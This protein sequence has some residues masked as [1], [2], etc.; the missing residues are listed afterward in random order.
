MWKSKLSR[1]LLLVAVITLLA[2]IP[3]AQVQ[4]EEPTGATIWTDKPDYSPEE[5]VTIFGTGFNALTGVTVTIE[6]PDR[7]MDT[8]SATTDDSGSFSCTYLLDGI[9]GTYLVTATDGTKMATTTF[10]DAISID[11]VSPSDSG[12]NPKTSFLTTDNV[13]ATI[14]Y[15][16]TGPNTVDAYLVTSIPS[17]SNPS[18]SDIRGSPTTVT[19]SE[20]TLTQLIWNAPTTA[21]TTYYIILDLNQ[22]GN[23]Q[24]SN[25]PISSIFTVSVPQCEVTFD[26]TGLDGDATSTVVSYEIDGGA[27]TDLAYGDLPETVWVDAGSEPPAPLYPMKSMVAH[28]RTLL[29]V[30]FRRRFGLTRGLR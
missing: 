6:R 8:V 20:S 9:I 10:T 19:F 13:Y 1:T 24:S 15:S 2:V 27:S 5:T 29:M 3:L 22:N 17:G 14:T 23:W 25:E 21:G 16:A 28:P 4:A 30:I 11:S 26:H 18:L 12:G 7:N